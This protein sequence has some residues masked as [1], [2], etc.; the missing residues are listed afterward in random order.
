MR[1]TVGDEHEKLV[2]GAVQAQQV[3]GV[4]QG[5]AHAGGALSGHPGQ[6]RSRRLAVGLLEVLEALVLDLVPAA[7]METVDG[8]GV[9]ARGHRLGR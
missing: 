2:A 3:S 8:E 6:P 7:R 4:P 5:H 9:A 1:L